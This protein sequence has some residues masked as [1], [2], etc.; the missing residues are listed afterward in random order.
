MDLPCLDRALPVADAE[1]AGIAPARAPAVLADPAFGRIVVADDHDAMPAGL[2]AGDVPVHA[3]A[4]GEE[5]IEHDEAR[6]KRS[7][8]GD[9]FLHLRRLVGERRVAADLD[10][11]A[12]PVGAAAGAILV[13]IG[14][15]EAG[16]VDDAGVL[17]M[18]EGPVRP[19]AVAAIARSEE[20]TSELQSR[21]YLV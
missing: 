18:L 4:I 7:P 21:Q 15:G 8:G 2:A 20:H 5:I 6:G 1:E 9:P 14:I 13:V 11:P 10:H 12:G 3:A 16:L 19:P 17:H